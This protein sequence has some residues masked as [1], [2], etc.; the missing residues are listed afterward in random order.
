MNGRCSEFEILLEVLL[1]GWADRIILDAG[2]V[3]H[4][5]VGVHNKNLGAKCSSLLYLLWNDCTQRTSSLGL[6]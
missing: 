3:G 1:G 2:V 4:D 6:S 5:G